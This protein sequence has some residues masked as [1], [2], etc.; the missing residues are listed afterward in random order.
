MVLSNGICTEWYIAHFS[1]G[2]MC[3]Q[4]VKKHLPFRRMFFQ[5]VY[6]K[7]HPPE[8]GMFF[9]VYM[10]RVLSYRAHFSMGAKIN[11]ARVL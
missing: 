6:Y 3:K 10:V 9:I 1:R 11:C 5:N 4:K 7:E 2:E 8:G